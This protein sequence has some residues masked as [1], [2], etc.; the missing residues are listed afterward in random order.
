MLFRFVKPGDRVRQFDEICEVQS[1]KASVAITSRYDGTIRSLHFKVDDVAMVG[2]ALLD[3]EIESDTE[4]DTA[5]NASKVELD[6]KKDQA[7][8]NSDQ[9]KRTT[10]NVLPEADNKLEKL[11]GKVL[12]TPA[13]RRLAMENNIRLIDVKATGKKGRVLKEDMLAHLEKISTAS[14]VKKEEVPTQASMMGETFELKGYSRHM[15][16]TMTKSLVSRQNE[17]SYL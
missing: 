5:E 2:A 6:L 9:E 7:I 3:I 12:T 1:D 4:E 16:K 11:V 17:N 8:S 10:D 14:Q 15:W 13:V